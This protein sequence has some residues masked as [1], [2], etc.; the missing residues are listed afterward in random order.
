MSTLSAA[1][2]PLPGVCSVQERQEEITFKGCMA[3]VTV[4]RCEGTCISA[5]SF[6]TITQQMDAHCGC[7]RPLHSHEQ[8]LE[9]PCPDPSAPGQ[10][11]VLTL[12]VFSRCEC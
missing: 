8:Q 9:L 12:Q 1:D 2:R 7:C 6:N 10:W 4:T 11:L 5:A 3:N